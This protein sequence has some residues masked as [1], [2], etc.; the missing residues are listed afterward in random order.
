MM[1]VAAS[2]MARAFGPGESDRTRGSGSG[3]MTGQNLVELLGGFPDLVGYTSQVK[4]EKRV[5]APTD[6]L[7]H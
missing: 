5:H 1:A 7:R 2:A 4:I 6:F 3:H